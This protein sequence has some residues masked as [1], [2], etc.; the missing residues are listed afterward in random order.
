MPKLEFGEQPIIVAYRYGQIG[1]CIKMPEKKF[2][3]ITNKMDDQAIKS[4]T[5]RLAEDL[6]NHTKAMR[7][8]RKIAPTMPYNG[9]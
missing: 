8:Q 4:F 7:K 2:K 5:E 6:K 3:G 9:F 1:F